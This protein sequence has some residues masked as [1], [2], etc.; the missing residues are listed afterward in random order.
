[1]KNF[2][3]IIFFAFILN[4]SNVLAQELSLDYQYS[5]ETQQHYVINV[6]EDTANLQWGIWLDNSEPEFG[7]HTM[8]LFLSKDQSLFLEHFQGV[9]EII[10]GNNQRIPISVFWFENPSPEYP[11]C[12]KVLAFEFDRYDS[13]RLVEQE[14]KKIIFYTSYGKFTARFADKK[15][16]QKGL[17]TLKYNIDIYN[18]VNAATLSDSRQE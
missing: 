7:V 11:N 9:A 8:K 13:N 18:Q 10:L 4:F 1:M 3:A 5:T 2:V 17:A 15:M 14:I 16:V 6:P 12:E